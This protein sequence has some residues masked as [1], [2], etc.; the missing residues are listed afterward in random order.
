[1]V[2]VDE[3]HRLGFASPNLYLTP[4]VRG[5]DGMGGRFRDIPLCGSAKEGE[6]LPQERSA[7][8]VFGYVFS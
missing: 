1:M 2:T 6:G 8:Y 4:R 3:A 5:I 7:A